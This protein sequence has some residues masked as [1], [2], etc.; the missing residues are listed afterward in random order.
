MWGFA[1]RSA[2]SLEVTPKH[3]EL[4]RDADDLAES[5]TRETSQNSADAKSTS[6]GGVHVRIGRA[7]VPRSRF[8]EAWMA[9][10]ALHMEAWE[11]GF[12]DGAFARDEVECLVIEDFGTK[13]LGGD[14]DSPGGSFYAFWRQYGK[15]P[16]HGDTGGRHGEGKSTLAGVSRARMFFG[17][18]VREED[19][20]RLLMGQTI[21]GPHEIDG[22]KYEAY[23]E[24]SPTRGDD[25]PAPFEDETG[26]KFV[27]DFGVTRVAEPGL[28]LV[29]PS[30]R[31]EIVERELEPIKRALVSN[32]FPQVASG[33][34]EFDV[35]GDALDA[36]TLADWAERWP[37]LNLAGA[38]SVAQEAVAQTRVWSAT[39]R[40]ELT[41][42]SFGDGE[43][44]A[45]RAAFA[46][47]ELVSVRVPVTVRR[48]DGGDRV[49]AM[50]LHLRKTRPGEAGSEHYA[51]S[52][53]TVPRQ[54]RVLAGREV[55]GLLMAEDGELSNFLGDA[56]PPS[57]ARWTHQ[58]LRDVQRYRRTQE[59]LSKVANALRQFERVLQ[60]EEAESVN[61]DAFKALFSRPKP[62]PRIERETDAP[63]P[64]DLPPARA[65]WT[66]QNRPGGFTVH[67]PA[68]VEVG[69]VVVE[70]AY[71]R[72]RGTADWSDAD[73][74]F[75]R[76]ATVAGVGAGE[77]LA[78]GNVIEIRSAE[79][80][81]RVEAA[82]FDS[83]RDIVVT[84]RATGDDDG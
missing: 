66:V 3:E 17:L 2:R 70:V 76:D 62:R 19:G 74:S 63:P 9:G 7:V 15:S 84:V 52:R 20:R 46:A 51:R 83:N 57:H 56:E 38:V 50:M 11:P 8:D 30:V 40:A 6:S 34:L 24:F 67:R 5:V 68:S 47:G 23:G 64:V 27:A 71:A 58:N 16:K 65:F 26:D 32:C 81:F 60:D 77:V 31:Q 39:E 80:G 69:N 73:F 10:L 36:G 82:G 44:Q 72:R 49:G 21:L 61:P 14:T 33:L 1:T 45:M 54:R 48:I 4:F 41:A 12:V 42:E 37:E 43:V 22:C 13:G 35:E 79:P 55:I 28:S 75:D 25:M 59:T 18:T 78:R 53:L 29:V